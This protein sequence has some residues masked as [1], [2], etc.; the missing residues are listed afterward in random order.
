ME[1]YEQIAA[2]LRNSDDELRRLAV[3]QLRD[4]EGDESLALLY[5][6]LGD[7]SWRV[8]K[9]VLEVLLLRKEQGEVEDLFLK[10]LEDD[11]NAGLRNSA[12]EGLEKMGEKVIP[13]LIGAI[14]NQDPDVRKFIV[15]IL[16]AIGGEVSLPALLE[17]LQDGD[18]NVRCAAA[19]ALGYIGGSQV[20]EALL[21]ILEENDLILQF[22]V[23]EALCRINAPLPVDVIGKTLSNPLL[24][25]AAFD[26]LG[27]SCD[28]KVIPILLE[29]VQDK[30]KNSR[31][32]AIVAF[33]RLAESIDSK[34]RETLISEAC[35]ILQ[36]GEGTGERILS[37]LNSYN[38][39][40]RRSAAILLGWG[41]ETRAAE[42][43]LSLAK[44]EEMKRISIAAMR[45][46]GKN[47]VPSLISF[48][49]KEDILGQ[50]VIC[51]VLGDIGDQ[52]A[53]DL[54]IKA[55][56]Q[57]DGHIRHSAALSLGKLDAFEALDS[58]FSLMEHEYVD[59]QDAAVQTL[60]T[61]GEKHRKP[62]IKK[63]NSVLPNAT[64]RLKKNVITVLGQIGG[65][66]E[67]PLLQMAF[68]DEGVEIRKSVMMALG[69]IG[70]AEGAECT[71][72]G[73]GDEDPE[74][75]VAAANALGSTKFEGAADALASALSDENMWVRCAAARG[76]GKLA[77]THCLP[78]LKALLRDEVG[79]VVIAVLRSLAALGWENTEN[80]ILTA[81]DHRDQEIVLT[82]IDLL[83]EN[84]SPS[85]L[86]VLQKL[87][88]HQ[89]ERVRYRIEK[90]FSITQETR[91]Q[92]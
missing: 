87:T 8:R 88:G 23:L 76:L 66:E 79:V 32:A 89:S 46:I 15:E 25:K 29:G 33:V 3:E 80:D 39:D 71:A 10:A 11:S 78:K 68:K 73:L 21:P 27:Y 85:D 6:A 77:D 54:L 37:S 69:E 67:I 38:T 9:M 53:K 42:S 74:V 61:L 7:Q 44:E 63:L 18:E 41:G 83:E 52:R 19:E 91:E 31:E 26:V 5:N 17:A 49:Q 81:L 13:K 2:H 92:H 12:I 57:S 50:R 20:I 34:H 40:V 4:S 14:N 75:R 82:A 72:L 1:G 51:E 28:P 90:I 48:Y 24:R 59:V 45:D 47:I 84:A 58:L 55:L 70:H 65:Q 60:T 64:R 56:K 16:G 43:L 22:S 62:I 36:E 35:R 30:S 86:S